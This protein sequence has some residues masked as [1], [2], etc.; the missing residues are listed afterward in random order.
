M[1]PTIAARR[2]QVFCDSQVALRALRRGNNTRA[3]HQAARQV[4]AV[5]LAAGKSLL[6]AWLPRETHEVQLCDDLSKLQTSQDWQ[7]EPAAFRA[8]GARQAHCAERV[9]GA[10]TIHLVR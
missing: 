2:I 9:N 1:A 7:L 8:L 4:W 3:V 6:P 10:Y 5:A